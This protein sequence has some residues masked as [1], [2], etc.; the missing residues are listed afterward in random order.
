V[1]FTVISVF[2]NNSFIIIT[3]VIIIISIIIII[4]ID[5]RPVQMAHGLSAASNKRA[6]TNTEHL[7]L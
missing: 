2:V 1:H 5:G 7:P 6:I 3:I 4:V